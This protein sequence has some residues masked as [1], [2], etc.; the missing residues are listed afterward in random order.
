[1]F[2]QN[3]TLKYLKITLFLE[4]MALFCKY[5]KGK[6]PTTGCWFLLG[7]SLENLRNESYMGNTRFSIWVQGLLLKRWQGVRGHILKFSKL[8]TILPYLPPHWNINYITFLHA[9]PSCPSLDW[10]KHMGKKMDLAFRQILAKISTAACIFR[11]TITIS[12][13]KLN[14]I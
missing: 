13:K 11:S 7:Y 14:F 3:F 9:N 5:Y 2:L 1:M 10:E 8:S 4:K 6:R 12:L